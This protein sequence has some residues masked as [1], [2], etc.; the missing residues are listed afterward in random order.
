M[1]RLISSL[2]LAGIL[3]ASPVVGQAALGDHTLKQGMTHTEVKQLQSVLKSKGYFKG[4]TTTY[5]GSATAAAVKSFQ[6]SRGL[7]A[8]GV[9]GAGTF[10]ALGVVSKPTSS[11][12]GVVSYSSASVISTAKKYMSVPYKWGGTTPSGFDCSGFLNYVYKK[13]AG[14]TLPRTVA[15]IYQKGSKVSSPKAGDIVFFHTYTSGASHAGIYVGNGK[16]IHSSSS[17]GVSIASLSNSYWSKR[18]MGAKSVR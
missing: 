6:K 3:L 9:V 10:K 1:K 15:G 11:V 13:S 16:F 18:Y 14:V 12:K 2:T 5:F 7:G 4:T 17:Q 8:D